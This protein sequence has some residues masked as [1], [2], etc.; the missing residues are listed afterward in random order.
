MY[1]ILLVEKS[2]SDADIKKAY[3][4][5]ALL[6]HPDKCSAPGI[7]NSYILYLITI[8]YLFNSYSFTIL[9]NG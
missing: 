2:C 9:R 1:G 7:H 3:R 8:L 5:L 6:Y 4:K